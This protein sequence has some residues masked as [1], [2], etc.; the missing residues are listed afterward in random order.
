MKK[1]SKSVKQKKK[2]RDKSPVPLTV[3]EMNAYTL[4]PHL[5]EMTSNRE[6]ALALLKDAGILDENGELAAPYIKNV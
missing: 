2:P 3:V 6:T 1:K 4:S 5:L